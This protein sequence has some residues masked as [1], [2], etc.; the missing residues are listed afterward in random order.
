V[1]DLEYYLNL[2][3]DPRRDRV[4][5]H[6]VCDRLNLT[7]RIATLYCRVFERTTRFCIRNKY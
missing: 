1:E 5:S 3:V 2:K 4:K 7:Q 6:S